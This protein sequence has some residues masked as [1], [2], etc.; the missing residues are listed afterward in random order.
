MLP[1]VRTTVS[2][3]RRRLLA[4]RRLLASLLAAVAVASG[5]RA[6][7]APPEPSEVVVTAARDLPAGSVLAGDDLTRATF[8]AGSAP[9]GALGSDDLVGQVLAAPVRAG[10]PLTDVRLVGPALAAEPGTT[11]VPVRLPDAAAVTLLDPGDAIDLV[12]TDPERGGAHVVVSDAM[13]LAV[14][15]AGDPPVAGQPGALVVLAV[16]DTSVT[17]V[18]EAAV[19]YFLGYAF[20]SAVRSATRLR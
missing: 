11:A 12:A 8:A 4:H 18:S 14:P 17:A 1:R 19:R 3:V 20:S 13:V 9:A 16:P 10:E 7:T 2:S 6:A 5:V 15:L